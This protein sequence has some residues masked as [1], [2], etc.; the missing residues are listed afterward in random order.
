VPVI[1]SDGVENL[2]ANPT[3]KSGRDNDPPSAKGSDAGGT[4]NKRADQQVKS[5]PAKDTPGSTKDHRPAG[6]QHFGEVK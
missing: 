5:G 3:V 6:V 1:K 4:D 2:R